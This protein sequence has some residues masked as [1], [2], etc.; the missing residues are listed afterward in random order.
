[1][2]KIFRTIL[3][4]LVVCAPLG[5]ALPS[6]AGPPPAA[7]KV[8]VL[9][10]QRLLEGDV[11][12]RDDQYCVRRPQGGEV[13][14]PATQV[15]KVCASREEA[16]NYVASLAD[17]RDPD[18]R[19]RLARWCQ[20][21]GLYEQGL[22]QATAALQ[23][24]PRHAEA[25]QLVELLKRA[26]QAKC[27][28]TAAAPKPAAAPEEALPPVDIDLETLGTFASRVQPILMNTC[29]QC[30]TA[31]KGGRFHLARAFDGATLNRKATQQNLTAVLAQVNADQLELSPFLIKAVSLHGNCVQPP[32]RGRDTPPYHAL[33]EWTAAALRSNPNLREATKNTAPQAP[34]LPG[35]AAGAGPFAEI[36][37]S[38]A[39]HAPEPPPSAAG[40]VVST[41]LPP[42]SEGPASPPPA[43]SVPQAQAVAPVDEFDPA[44]FNRQQAPPP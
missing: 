25:R 42:T 10:N 35:P 7:G 2:P 11:E 28:Q 41:A 33:R 39:A 16:F 44:L 32:I 8:I 21:N 30:H 40:V 12:L 29:L 6:R 15:L 4:A 37:G 9:E 26:A 24:R 38:P 17:Q 23:M 36:K 3:G 18:E 13:W 31:G 19:L 27:T 34:S 1:M 14:L 5:G 20:M 43:K 22:Q